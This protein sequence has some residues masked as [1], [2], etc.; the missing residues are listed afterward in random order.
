MDRVRAAL[1]VE[2]ASPSLVQD[3]RKMREKL[4]ATASPRNLKRGRGG[5]VDVEFL[6]Q[7]FQIRLGAASPDVI[8]PNVWDAIDALEA[9]GIWTADDAATLRAGYSFLRNV[10]ARLRIVT[11]RPLTEI[12]EQPADLAKLARRLGFP[13]P[14]EFLDELTSTTSRI[15]TVYDRLTR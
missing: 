12:P 13:S 2:A 14:V 8:R 15:R 4:E 10:E 1:A 6:V 5:I 11:D 7:L 3:V 9:A